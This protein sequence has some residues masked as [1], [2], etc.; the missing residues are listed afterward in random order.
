MKWNKLENCLGD[1]KK[2]LGSF[3]KNHVGYINKYLPAL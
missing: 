2:G 3:S 1:K